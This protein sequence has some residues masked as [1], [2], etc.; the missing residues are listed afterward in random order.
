MSNKTPQISLADVCMFHFD[1]VGYCKKAPDH[2][3]H[4]GMG[5]SPREHAFQDT[6]DEKPVAAQDELAAEY[7][8]KPLT[9]RNLGLIARRSGKSKQELE[10]MRKVLIAKGK[11]NVVRYKIVEEKS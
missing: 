2:L 6:P 10:L 7:E 5:I 4:M 1:D 8:S 9:K 11:S 3:V